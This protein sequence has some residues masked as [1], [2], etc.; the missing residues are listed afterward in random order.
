MYIENWFCLE[1]A[2]NTNTSLSAGIHLVKS[3][4]LAITETKTFYQQMIRTLIYAA[5]STRSNIAFTATQ[6]SQ[7]NNN[8][9]ETHKVHKVCT[10]MSL[11]H[12]GVPD[13]V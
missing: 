4:K 1:D 6:L 2:N 10:E 11:R 7:Y 5:I 9:M 8:P 12:K 13:Q 3:E